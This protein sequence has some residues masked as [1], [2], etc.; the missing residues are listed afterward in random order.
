MAVPNT[1]SFTLLNIVD[2]VNPSTDNLYQS[3]EEY[4]ADNFDT[5]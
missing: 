2:E 3:F 5:S 1:D 4:I